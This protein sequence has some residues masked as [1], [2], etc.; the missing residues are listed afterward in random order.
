M[1][2]VEDK[3]HSELFGA[4]IQS[5]LSEGLGFRFRA[6]GRSM[7]PTIQDGE[8]LHVKPVSVENLRKGDIVLFADRSNYKAHRLLWIDWEQG[9]FIARG[10]AGTVADGALGTGQIVGQVVAKE[11]NLGGQIRVVPLCGRRVRIKFLARRV[12]AQAARFVRGLRALRSIRVR[13][14]ARKSGFGPISS[15]ALLA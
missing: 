7:Q 14:C 13:G 5:L 10:D 4:L 3:A 11:E 2:V 8:I 12:R 6:C 15:L 1:S 9:A